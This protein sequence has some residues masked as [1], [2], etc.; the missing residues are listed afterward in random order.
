MSPPVEPLL[1]VVIVDDEAPARSRL[2]DL[3]VDCAAK[4]PLEVIGEA[5]TGREA[6]ELLQGQDADVVLL[7]IRMPEMDGVELA[8][9][10][11]KLPDPPAVV[12]IT[13]YDEYAVKAFELNAIDYLMKPIRASRLAEALA[14]AR[15]I[16]PL[17]ADLLRGLS[18][19]PRQHLSVTEGG[20]VYLVPMADILY[21]KAELKYV[22]IRT[23]QREYLIEESLTRLEQEY[24]K[25]F[26]RIHRNCLVSR[27]AIVGFERLSSA[28]S[29]AHW[30]VLLRGLTEKLAISRRQQHIVRDLAR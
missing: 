26:V 18:D 4:V 3:L 6:L 24:A 9:H 21:F 1:R 17:R 11:L 25:R 7:D 13:A 30:V 8:T 19:A 23:A 28:E 16:A 22:T 2:R 14:K 10:L 20:K 12:F 27:D 15:A 29:D 5:A